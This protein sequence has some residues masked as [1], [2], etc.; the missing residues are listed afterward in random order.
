[1]STTPPTRASTAGTTSTSGG[2]C[3]AFIVAAASL[4]LMLVSVSVAATAESARTSTSILWAALFFFV[5]LVCSGRLAFKAALGPPPP[6]ERPAPSP[7][8]RQVTTDPTPRPAQPAVAQRQAERNRMIDEIEDARA[9][10]RVE[11]A[12]S[13]ARVERPDPQGPK[14]TWTHPDVWAGDAA[15]ADL[16]PGEQVRTASFTWDV[17]GG[18]PTTTRSNAAPPAVA[19]GLLSWQEAEVSA[20]DWMRRHGHRDAGLT[21]GGPDGG[22]DVVASRAIAQ[23]KCWTQPVGPSPVLELARVSQGAGR[24]EPLFFSAS[25][26]TSNA[27]ASARAKGVQ[28]YQ[29]GPDG[30]TWTRVF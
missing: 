2:G 12:R 9:T 7:V 20:R 6:A 27:R 13:R 25:G 19:A 26:Y 1:M 28:L 23:V 16:D 30:R 18:R 4:A 3:L 10:A 8:T 29:L 24:R 5:V 22:V 15:Q 11:A 14:V 21:P 17:P